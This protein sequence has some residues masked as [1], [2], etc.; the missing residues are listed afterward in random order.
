VT[1]EFTRLRKL[2]I[3]ASLQTLP[4]GFRVTLQSGVRTCWGAGDTAELALER[5]LRE[6]YG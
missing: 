1:A 3:Y 4:S 2:C 5:A 6:W